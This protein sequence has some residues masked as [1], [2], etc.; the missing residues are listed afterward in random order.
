[1]SFK[2]KAKAKVKVTMFTCGHC[3][4]PYNNLFRHVCVVRTTRRSGGKR[5]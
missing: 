2:P 5:K 3:G 4:K 1:M